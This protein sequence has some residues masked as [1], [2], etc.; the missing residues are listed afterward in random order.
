[1]LAEPAHSTQAEPPALSPFSPFYAD[2]NTLLQS[3]NL[4][5]LCFTS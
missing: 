3:P 5:P 1:M 2:Y 4:M